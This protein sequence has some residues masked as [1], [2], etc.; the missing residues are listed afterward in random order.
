[1][2]LRMTRYALAMVLSGMVL[3]ACEST[4]TED[5]CGADEYG[6]LVGQP[7][8]AVTLPADLDARIIGPDTAVTM[9]HRPDRLNIA[10][11]GSGI[12][13]TVYCG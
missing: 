4:Q 10:V 6:G 7:L 1:M 11:D 12:I 9:D 8:A 5:A 2:R 13:E 3:A